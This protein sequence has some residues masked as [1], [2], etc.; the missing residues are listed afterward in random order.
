MNLFL[1]VRSG[2]L[3]LSN[4]GKMFLL[5]SRLDFMHVH[6]CLLENSVKLCFEFSNLKYA[7]KGF[8]I[9]FLV[10]M[11]AIQFYGLY[12]KYHDKD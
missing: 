9:D 1:L 11:C 7:H 2:S 3:I 10:I 4:N 5:D 8:E 12:R 6:L